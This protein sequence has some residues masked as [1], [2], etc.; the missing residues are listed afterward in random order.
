MA[1]DMCATCEFDGETAT[2]DGRIVW[3]CNVCGWE[4]AI[5]EPEMA[6]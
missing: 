4:H 2:I 5:P 3:V 6:R 1:D